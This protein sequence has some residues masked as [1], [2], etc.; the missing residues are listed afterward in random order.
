MSKR[1]FFGCIA[2]AMLLSSG[3]AVIRQGEIGTKRTFGRLDPAFLNAGPHFY[4]PFVTQVIVLPVRTVNLEMSLDLP[5]EE[6]LTI[7]AGISILYHLK[8]EAVPKILEEIGSNYE[9]VVIRNVF[10]SA[11]ADVCARFA[12]KDMYSGARSAIEKEI[13][14][15]M[16]EMLGQRG[17]VIESVLLKSIKLPNGLARAIE[18]KLSSEQEAQR[19]EFVLQR[20]RKEA[21]RRKIEAEGIRDAQQILS[22]GLTKEIIHLRSIEAFQELATSPN[23]KVIVT[24]GDGSFLIDA[25]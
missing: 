13:A 8:Q 17:F 5:S 2:L 16:T 1:I 25:K 15:K 20:E 4:N 14:D 10:R 9:E 11:A 24:D 6:G 7:T 18:D 3:C 12:A 22:Q 21:E 19:M 23:T